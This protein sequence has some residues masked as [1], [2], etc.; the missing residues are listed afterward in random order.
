M[1]STSLFDDN[2]LELQRQY[3]ERWTTFSRKAMG[4]DEPASPSATWESMLDHWWQTVSPATPDLSRTL[5]ERLLEQGKLFFRLAD[6]L[7]QRHTVSEGESGLA[8]WN[9]MLQDM[10]KAFAGSLQDRDAPWARL[11]SFWEL[12][13]DNWQRMMSSLSPLPGDLLRNMPYEQLKNSLDRALSAPGL[14]YTREEQAQYQA[15]VRASMDYQAALQDYVAFYQRLGL[16]SIERMGSYLQGVMESGQIIDSARA[17]Y[18]NWVSCCEAAYAEEVATPEYARIHGRLVNT[19]MTLKQR[20]SVLVDENL[21][22]FNMPTR[23]ELR[24][25]QV[26]LQET[27]RENKALERRLHDLEQR[28]AMLSGETPPAAAVRSPT[29]RRAKSGAA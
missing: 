12:P 18:D 19:Q 10:Q 26:R 20:L 14:G 5:M 27:R 1:T 22:A 7:M 2:W 28:L 6:T 8:W 13:L 4:L 11:L 15:L 23:R 29:R 9:A 21:G 16:K 24:T 25:L 3:W 17:L